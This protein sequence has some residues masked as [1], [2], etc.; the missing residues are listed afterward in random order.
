MS[1]YALKRGLLALFLFSLPLLYYGPNTNFSATKIAFSM[2]MIS[3]LLLVELV[4]WVRCRTFSLAA[5][6]LLWPASLLLVAMGLS[7]FHSDNLGLS[8][9]TLV[10]AVY[11]FAL[12]LLI[13]N[14]VRKQSDVYL[15][16][17]SLALSALV[18]SAY[19]LLQ[20]HGLLPGNPQPRVPSERILS[21]VGNKNFLGG[22]LAY[23]VYPTFSL[24][25]LLKNR[26]AKTL[27]LVAQALVFLTVVAINSDGVWLA[28]AGATLFWWGAVVGF[29]LWGPLRENRVWLWGLLA[30]TALGGASLTAPASW[31]ALSAFS[32][33]SAPDV[34]PLVGDW[35][36]AQQRSVALYFASDKTLR[37]DERD[38]LQLRFGVRDGI[39][40]A[41]DWNGD[42][43][44]D[45]A[46]YSQGTFYWDVDLDGKVD[47]T[48]AW[49]P[50]DAWPLAGDWNGDGVVEYG[51]FRGDIGVFT[52]ERSTTR[53][54]VYKNR[55]A[56][57]GDLPVVGDWN[58]DGQDEVGLYWPAEGVFVLDE[59][60][61]GQF[62]L[63]LRFDRS[64]PGDLPLVS[65][66]RGQTVLGVFRPSTQTML[67]DDTLDGRVDRTQRWGERPWYE[68]WP[69]WLKP[70]LLIRFED[71]AIGLAMLQ[72]HPW[73]GVGLANYRLKFLPYKAELLK[74]PW[75]K[76]LE[77]VEQTPSVGYIPLA[78]HAHNEYVQLGAELGLLG[79]LA[80]GW[81]LFRVLQRGGDALFG[82]A[83]P[84][85]RLMNLGILAGLVGLFLDAEVSFP[86]YLPASALVLTVLLGLLF[87]RHVQGGGV[88]LK[89]TTRQKWSVVPLVL[90]VC[91]LVVFASVRGF[92]ADL[93]VQQG[94]YANAIGFTHLGARDFE[95]SLALD[96]AP[97]TALQFLGDYYSDE[98][99]QRGTTELIER[100]IRYNLWA[101]RALPTEEGYWDLGRCYLALDDD[102]RALHYFKLLDAVDPEGW[103]KDELVRSIDPF[104]ERALAKWRA[105]DRTGALQGLDGLSV[106]A[107]ALGVDEATQTKLDFCRASLRIESGQV[108]GSKEAGVDILEQLVTNYPAYVPAHVELGK[109]LPDRNGAAKHAQT[110]RSLS[111][112]QNMLGGVTAEAE[113]TSTV[114]RCRA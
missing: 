113:G 22:M 109:V 2:V 31:N 6:G 27:L 40:L 83:P 21:T 89:P 69:A 110:A 45:V 51:A 47:V 102:E 29:R 86:L 28:L 54:V 108:G 4:A 62:D 66:K 16:V 95:R 107:Q 114:Q 87:S 96:V 72:D 65:R 106:I 55:S 23:L 3:L 33:R 20:Y 50:P 46:L 85:V 57:P 67:W 73:T 101:L 70:S 18:A 30:T 44:T 15:F 61:D 52:L 9:R 79:L 103:L 39:P 104:Y 37:F 92:V 68:G 93:K 81:V 14:A 63:K 60:G 19:G 1:F 74:T 38:R 17:G 43:R 11:F 111:E 91:G 59:N 42:G 13:A 105:G 82:N 75:G 76:R 97:Q 48:Y 112:R 99:E 98:A 64:Q 94:L 24:F 100:C 53:G 58:G 26:T 5:S 88:E 7:L 34:V 35:N 25:L 84:E 8:L 78:A 36:A 32:Q 71:W 10:I 56:Q 80:M 49:G 90:A 41:G 12:L 77:S